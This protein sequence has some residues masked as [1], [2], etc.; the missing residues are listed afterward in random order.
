MKRTLRMVRV[1]ALCAAA[2]LA[3]GATGAA[4]CQCGRVPP[5]DGGNVSDDFD[6][7]V[8]AY[9]GFVDRCESTFGPV[10]ESQ[11]ACNVWYRGLLD[12]ILDL[13][14]QLNLQV[15]QAALAQCTAAINALPCDPDVDLTP[16]CGD[17]F[18]PVGGAVAGQPCE[19]LGCAAGLY[20]HIEFG[21]C[22]ECR[23]YATLGQD[24]TSAQ[25]DDTTTCDFMTNTCVALGAIGAPC[26]FDSD[27]LSDNCDGATN[28]CAGPQ[29]AGAA[30]DQDSDCM[31]GRCGS[32]S[33][34]ITPAPLGGPC[35][36]GQDC[37]GFR[38]CSSG[39]VCVDRLPPGSPC[40]TDDECYADAYCTGGTCTT[41]VACMPQPVGASCGVIFQPC[42]AGAYCASGPTGDVCTPETPDG[43]PCA[44]SEECADQSYCDFT[45]NV[46]TP[47]SPVGGPC[48]SQ[49]DC[50]DGAYCDMAMT[51]Q[52]RGANGAP[53]TDA[54]ACE[55]GYCDTTA[56]TCA[57]LPSCMGM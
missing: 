35:G 46:C 52:A 34:C 47:R 6:A 50:V 10:F 24:C 3:V 45:T 20:C 27:C 26:T 40:M 8:A 54:G 21:T 16:E 37:A 31:S 28:L 49:F 55:S 42:V 51:C 39:G 33:T 43:Q 11:A 15:N 30:C 41:Y 7:Y 17:V 36:G 48:T 14:D 5:G 57:D 2:A 32:A 13:F 53:C 56:G 22:S 38:G 23:A 44:G 12:C 25:C 19:G 1:A 4:G 9:C 29:P 18:T